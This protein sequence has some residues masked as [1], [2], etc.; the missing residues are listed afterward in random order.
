M[1]AEAALEELV[2]KEKEEVGLQQRKKHATTK[3][4]N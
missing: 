4:K 1:A 3:A 2:G